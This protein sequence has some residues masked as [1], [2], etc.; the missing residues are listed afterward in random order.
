MNQPLA[1]PDRESLDRVLS[2]LAGRLV[3]SVDFWTVVCL[4]APDT[5][6]DRR[7]F[8]DTQSQVVRGLLDQIEALLIETGAIGE[9]QVRGRQGDLASAC[10]RLLGAFGVLVAFQTVP[11]EDI[12]QTTATLTEA[13]SAAQVSIRSLALAVGVQVPCITKRALDQDEYIQGILRNLFPLFQ[14]AWMT[15]QSTVPP[16]ATKVS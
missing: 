8:V 1:G 5:G 9:E 2:D 15:S 11:L 14:Q 6:F 7:G 4:C 12:R 3:G 10:D 16:S 13:Y